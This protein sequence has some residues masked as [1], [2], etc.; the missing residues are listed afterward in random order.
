[1]AFEIVGAGRSRAG[2]TT[3]KFWGLTGATG[4]PTNG[5]RAPRASACTGMP[6]P[7]R[8]ARVRVRGSVGRCGGAHVASSA[9][10]HS[11]TNVG[12]AQCRLFCYTF[13]GASPINIHR[14]VSTL[15]GLPVSRV[16]SPLRFWKFPGKTEGVW[17]SILFLSSFPRENREFPC[18]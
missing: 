13:I 10:P 12:F 1:M 14:P 17:C 18:V 4:S 6:W 7:M 16:P 9:M 2:V 5:P 3:R 8:H 11:P 15:I